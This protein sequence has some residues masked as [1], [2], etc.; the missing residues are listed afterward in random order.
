M[1]VYRRGI[2]K[3]IIGEGGFGGSSVA[4]R[5]GGRKSIQMSKVKER[6]DAGGSK[7]PYTYV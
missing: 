7:R 2:R 3:E 1:R 6:T 4:E 5:E